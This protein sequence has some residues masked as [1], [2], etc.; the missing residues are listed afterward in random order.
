M[1]DYIPTN[2]VGIPW[3][4][5]K[6]DFILNCTMNEFYDYIEENC[7]IFINEDKKQGNSTYTKQDI[8]DTINFYKEFENHPQMKG[9]SPIAAQRGLGV[10]KFL[11][12]VRIRKT[13]PKFFERTL[14]NLA[15]THRC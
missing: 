2:V 5:E 4:K 11:Y 15:R 8:I 13:E 9:A 6:E 10:G 12:Y 7:D 1:E 14:A 3:N